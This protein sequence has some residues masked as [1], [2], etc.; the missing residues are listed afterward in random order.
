VSNSVV[1]I[2]QA[3]M[4]STRLPGK[5][6]KLLAG[7]P[8]LQRVIERIKKAEKINEIILAIPDT[9]ENLVLE[10]LGKKLDI[11]VYKG[12]ENDLVNRYVNAA[13][14]VKS[15]FV[16][17]IPA[18]NPVPQDSEIDRII[19]HH[20]QLGRPGFSSNLAEIF[21]SGYPDGIGAEI[22]DTS[23]L[24]EIKNDF[25]TPDKREHVHLNFFNYTTQSV[26]DENWCPVSTIKCPSNFARPDLVLDVNTHEQFIFMSKLYEYLYPRNPSF[27]IEA[28]VEWYDNHYVKNP[29]IEN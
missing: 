27:G 21:Q 25:S 1:A 7:K 20:L 15:D 12:S 24:D 4:G 9:S 3:R 22:F 6:M 19:N 26:V 18:D 11:K 23:Y 28:I 29:G 8:L 10:E 2:V 17:R 16:V 13:R 14:L 5:S